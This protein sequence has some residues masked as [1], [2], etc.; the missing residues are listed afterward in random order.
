MSKHSTPRRRK[1]TPVPILVVENNAEQWLIIRAVLAQT[2]PEVTPIWM[3]NTAQTIAYLQTHADDPVKLPRLILAEL[4]L[5]RREDGV[6]ILE[7]IKNSAFYRKPPIITLSFSQT[8][9]DIALVYSFSVA[10]YIVKPS[11]YHEWLNC[12][13]NFRRYWWEVVTLP[14]RTQ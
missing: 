6:A 10:S 4:Y 1:E 7:F 14:L 5:P 11:T 9:E 8:T 2:F 3:N 13:Y 12:L